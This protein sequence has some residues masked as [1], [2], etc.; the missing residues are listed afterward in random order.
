MLSERA[1]VDSR[2]FASDQALVEEVACQLVNLVLECPSL[3]LALSGGR[4]VEPLFDA[5][6]R[7]SQRRW[8]DWSAVRFF[9]ADERSVPPDHAA[10]N[11]R[12]AKEHLLV[13]M[14]ISANHVHRIRGENDPWTAANEGEEQLRGALADDPGLDLVLLGM[15]EDGHVAS[16]FPG[17]PEQ[18]P[19]RLY[20]PVTSPKPPPSRITLTLLSLINARR[21]WVVAAGHGKAKTL[22]RALAGDP[23][24]PL[25]QVIARRDRTRV[26]SSVF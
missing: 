6:V 12:L 13:P 19:G 8:V 9:W 25:A 11:Y 22:Q 14:G 2:S 17:A 21:A 20:I 23:E 10:S 7:D 5:V 4:I 3:R 15:G 18:P 24:L 1:A 16:I 26:F